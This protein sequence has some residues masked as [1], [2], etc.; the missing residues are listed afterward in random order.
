[1][2]DTIEDNDEGEERRVEDGGGHSIRRERSNELSA[3]WF[4]IKVSF[5]SSQN[6]GES[7][8]GCVVKFEQNSVEEVGVSGS[9]CSAGKSDSPVPTDEEESTAGVRDEISNRI[10]GQ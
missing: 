7:L 5:R 3:N 8:Q 9:V 4:R 6:N 10:G 1:L 2:H